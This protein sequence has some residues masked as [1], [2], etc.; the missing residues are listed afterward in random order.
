MLDKTLEKIWVLPH[1]SWYKNVQVQKKLSKMMNVYKLIVS[2]R[3][4]EEITYP[5]PPPTTIIITTITTTM[6]LSKPSSCYKKRKKKKHKHK[7]KRK[8][9]TK[10]KKRK[11]KDF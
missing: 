4:E 5:S 9:K 3:E 7:Q 11:K 10:T 2:I 1:A 6:N 8:I